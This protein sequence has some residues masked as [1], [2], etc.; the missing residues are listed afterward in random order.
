MSSIY[1]QA[2]S[3]IGKPILDLFLDESD[4]KEDCIHTLWHLERDNRGSFNQ[5]SAFK[6][7]WRLGQKTSDYREDLNKA[8]EYFEWEIEI[9]KSLSKELAIEAG[10]NIERKSIVVMAQLAA[11]ASISVL[12]NAIAECKL[13]IAKYEEPK[14]E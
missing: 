14:H 2:P 8:I 13:L 1:Y 11:V 5:Y 6:Y 4:Y 3:P 10:N 7:L 9:V 12:D